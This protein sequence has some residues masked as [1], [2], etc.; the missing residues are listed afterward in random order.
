MIEPTKNDGVIHYTYVHQR[1]HQWHLKNVIF[2]II[3][4]I[5]ISV[6]KNQP[7]RIKVLNI[8]CIKVKRMM[9]HLYHGTRYYL[10]TIKKNQLESVRK[11]M[12]ERNQKRFLKNIKMILSMQLLMKTILDF[13]V[14]N[15]VQKLFIK[16]VYVVS[17]L[18]ILVAD[19]I[20]RDVVKAVRITEN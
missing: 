17:V 14:V 8:E 7:D 11:S 20:H 10:Q 6:Q 16:Q 3:T 12:V 2:I 19:H 1:D 15:K 5:I 9:V 4:T 13:L 18:K